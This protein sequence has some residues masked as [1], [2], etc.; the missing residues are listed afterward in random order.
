MIDIA[1][2]LSQCSEGRVDGVLT[3]DWNGI[4]MENIEEKFYLKNQICG[5]LN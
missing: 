3:R 5:Y 2:L 4:Q 1:G